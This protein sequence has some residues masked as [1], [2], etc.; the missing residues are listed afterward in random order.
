MNK[1]TKKINK[2]LLII[3]ITLISM[4]T[5][6]NASLKNAENDKE[7]A[8][9]AV[10]ATKGKNDDYFTFDARSLLGKRIEAADAH[11]DDKKAPYQKVGEYCIDNRAS[12]GGA[13]YFKVYNIIDIT[14]EGKVIS[15][16]SKGNNIETTDATVVKLFK[17]LA[18]C[19]IKSIEANEQ[20]VTANS[21]KVALQG[22]VSEGKAT[23]M[24][25]LGLNKAFNVSIGTNSSSATKRKEAK[26]ES[27]NKSYTGR[28]IFLYG[29]GGQ[30]QII[31]GAK[32]GEGI[33]DLTI[34]K[35]GAAN[36]ALDKVGFILKNK[37]TGEYVSTASTDS[38][39]KY[40]KN[41][42]QAKKYFTN[43][44][45]KI[46]IKGLK[47]GNYELYET[48]N[49]HYGYVVDT[50]KGIK[51]KINGGNNEKTVTNKQ[52]YIRLSGYVWLDIEDAKTS[53]K[54]G[55]Y[56]ESNDDIHDRLFNGIT[57]RL[58]DKT[59]GQTV[60]ETKTS[61]LGRYNDKGNNGNGEY[62]FEEVLISKLKDYYVEFEYD[63]LTYQNVIPQFKDPGSKAVEP[64][65]DSWNQNFSVVE[66]E[67]RETGY[68]RDANGNRKHNLSYDINEEKS[69]ATLS[70]QGKYT[71]NNEC[72]TQNSIGQ[73]TITANTDKA[74][75]ALKLEE[76]KDEIRYVNLGLYEREQPQIK[77]EKDLHNVRLEI[78]GYGHTYNYASKDKNAGNFEGGFNVGIQFGIQGGNTPY[79]RAIYK[80]DIEYASEDKS[81]ELK[82][83]M[84]YELKIKNQSSSL[85]TQVNSIVDYFDKNYTIE[86]YGTK[87]TSQGKIE[88]AAKL[89]EEAFNGNTKYKK[90]VIPVNKKITKENPEH[91]VYI[92]FAL[93]KEAILKVLNDK[94]NL[95][96]VAEINSYS[97]FKDGK[98][99][100]GIDKVSNP[101]NA[102]LENIKSY[103]GDTDASPGLKL[104]LTDAPRT[105]TGKV[106]L[107]DHGTKPTLQTGE[108]R[109]GDGKYADGEKGI[110]GVTVTL[111]EEGKEPYTATTNDNGDFEIKNYVPGNYTLTYT[112]GDQTYTVQKYK[113][114]VYKKDR[115]QDKNWYKDEVDTRYTDA[116]DNY[117][118]RL[119]IDKEMQTV[120]Q[121][122]KVTKT[123]MNSTTPIMGLGIE[124]DDNGNEQYGITSIETEYDGDK[125]VPVGYNIRNIDFG[126]IERAKQQ[127]S[128]R[129]RIKTL[130]ATLA[131]GQIIANIE[132]DE[133]GNITGD[134]QNITYMKP[135]ATTTPNNGFVRLELDNELIQGTILE[136]GY[137]IKATNESE[138]DF[139][140]EEYYLYGIQTGEEITITPNR[141]IDYLDKNWAIDEKK[142]DGWVIKKIEDIQDSI[143]NNVL[144]DEESTI[145]NKLI[146]ETNKLSNTKL[147]A[148]DS[149][150][151]DLNVSKILT[152]T[153]EIS[154]DNETEVLELTRPG[155]S[156]PDAK[157]GNYV[158][159]KG[160]Q[161]ADD[162]MAETTIV[163]PATGENLNYIIPVLMGTSALLVLG[164]GIVLIKK[165]V[166]DNK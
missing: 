121:Q 89:T 28:F 115:N 150:T 67:S 24:D 87:L 141:I 122:T 81:K 110:A 66:G 51:V 124:K 165:K 61:K 123:E 17:K 7:L 102:V 84:T 154:L 156:I 90:A 148:G 125:F 97:I 3:L 36:K 163:T 157:P 78:N 34:K 68:T 70:S 159:G 46:T 129:K 93:S 79:T 41:K 4:I 60:K 54:N 137:E 45:G 26:K 12:A 113:G 20:G 132:I 59:N 8:S 138:K 128:L 82:A 57:V 53:K 37:D 106:F 149:A 76:G 47:L 107:D 52:V 50:S 136:V 133:N 65:R 88:D 118:E 134:N 103:E 69:T 130:K 152:T 153:D 126:I 117:A 109:Q 105:L 31:F 145:A 63:G 72:I 30:N 116:I 127:L 48:E 18:Y 100:A 58:K 74:G 16:K 42:E 73:Y 119:E 91:N 142:N 21:W 43:T 1:R 75:Y 112:W 49:P 162:S 35:T 160:H 62:L 15:Y 99:Y 131:N 94:E 135:D 40:T 114:T 147:K 92:T 25:K 158:P 5:I 85:T 22:I 143:A 10:A 29:Q 166:L 6:V 56:H 77:L 39:A 44:E 13:S 98:I 14:P 155:G 140:S 9:A 80:S 104:Q 2:I 19:S 161:E 32:E 27:V 108:I 11:G 86:S 101:A 33:G 64:N 144:E 83:Y 151:V 164:A 38:K 111:K 120:N 95:N 55:L 139:L 71:K 23:M 146:L 96:N